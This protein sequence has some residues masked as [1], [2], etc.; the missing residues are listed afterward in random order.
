LSKPRHEAPFVARYEFHASTHQYGR[1]CPFR[2]VKS[3][4]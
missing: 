1:L 3:T 2:A 4:G